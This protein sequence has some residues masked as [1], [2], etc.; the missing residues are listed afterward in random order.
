[1]T[2]PSPSGLASVPR[3]TR[4][5]ANLWLDA[6]GR[7]RDAEAGACSWLAYDRTQLVGCHV[8]LVLPALNG[9]AMTPETDISPRLALLGGLGVGL[10]ARRG[11]GQEVAC[12]LRLERVLTDDGPMVCVELHPLG[13]PAERSFGASR[14][15]FPLSAQ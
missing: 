8:S 3:L 4:A 7:I 15:P 12:R 9:E 11:S 6:D 14:T 5:P 13:E 10:K 1:M 2:V